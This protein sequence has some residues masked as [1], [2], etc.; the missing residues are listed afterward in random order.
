MMSDRSM[1]RNHSVP[2]MDMSS[3]SNPEPIQPD[4]SRQGDVTIPQTLERFP[5]KTRVLLERIPTVSLSVRSAS[6]SVPVS[7]RLSSQTKEI[8]HG[9]HQEENADAETGQ[10][11]RHRSCRTVGDRQERGRR[12]MQTGKIVRRDKTFCVSN[13]LIELSDANRK[14]KFVNF[15]LEV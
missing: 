14:K 2:N 13:M 6:P 10:G 1:R 15:Y 12:Q 4:E 7:V 11:E 9:G 8:N 5:K 3:G